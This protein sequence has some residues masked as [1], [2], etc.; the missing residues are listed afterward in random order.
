MTDQSI[1]PVKAEAQKPKKMNFVKK[2]GKKPFF[3]KNRKP[4]KT[5]DIDAIQKKAEELFKSNDRFNDFELKFEKTFYV[6]KATGE[7]K[8]LDTIAMKVV[9]KQ[10]EE[11]KDTVER[12]FKIYKHGD[13]DEVM[14]K[15]MKW[16]GAQPSI[17]RRM[18]SDYAAVDAS[19]EKNNKLFKATFHAL[20]KRF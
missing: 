9:N 20:G 1:K 18:F 4:L 7:K 2:D 15:A 14:K 8:T 19:K 16:L 13:N 6:D 10:T 5:V 3:K 17:I 12:I 11:M